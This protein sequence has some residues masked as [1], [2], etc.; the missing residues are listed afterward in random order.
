M[1]TTI[2]ETTPS[3]GH[4]AAASPIPGGPAGRY[5]PR[6]APVAR[7]G[8]SG[9]TVS[10]RYHPAPPC[11]AAS[12]AVAQNQ[13]WWGANP[14]LLPNGRTRPDEGPQ[15]WQES[16]KQACGTQRPNRTT[17]EVEH[18]LAAELTPTTHNALAF[19]LCWG[20]CV[21]PFVGFPSD[22]TRWCCQ[23]KRNR[24]FASSLQGDRT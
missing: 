9:R 6:G 7:S 23:R 10:Y 16:A 24:R 22:T 8:Q 2:E 17:T 18:L 5:R 21:F 11:G 14:T 12:S 15:R 13:T 20:S 1:R 3:A 19:F 4:A